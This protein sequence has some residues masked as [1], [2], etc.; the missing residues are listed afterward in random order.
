MSEL[1]PEMRKLVG[2][3][4]Q[5]LREFGLSDLHSGGVEKARAFLAALAPPAETLSP[6]H[7]VENRA[8]PGPGGKIPVRIYHPSDKDHLPVLMW[9]HGGGWVLGT[10]DFAEAT[11]RT[12]PSAGTPGSRP[13]MRASCPVWR[14]PSS[15]PPNSTLCATR[16]RL[17]ARRWR[18]PGSRLQ[19]GG[20]VR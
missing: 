2:Q 7:C 17:T 13:S 4:E 6:I 5:A 14:R 20:T 18:L 12:L 11:C 1:H 3:L 8:I 9:F 15:S 19:P 10:L 16:P